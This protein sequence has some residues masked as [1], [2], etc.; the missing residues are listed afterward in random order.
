MSPVITMLEPFR[1]DVAAAAARFRSEGW[2]HAAGGVDPTF[3]ATIVAQTERLVDEHTNELERWRFPDKK[4]QFLWELPEGLTIDRLCAAV[5]AVAG[6]DPDTTVLAERHLKVYRDVAE[7]MPPAHKDRSASTLTVGIGISIPPESRLV[8][9]PHDHLERNP[10]PTSAEWRQSRRPDELP[11]RALADLTPIEVD[12][13]AGDVVMF[14]G[15]EIYHER[16]RPANASVLYLKFNDLGLDPLA[17]D[18]RTPVLEATSAAMAAQGFDGVRTL[19]L[20]RRV[21]GL[22]TEEFF[23]FG[24]HHTFARI[25]DNDTGVHLDDREVELL[26]RV[27]GERAVP[28]EALDAED[29]A[30]ARAL[31]G[32]GILLAS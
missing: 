5:A 15:A 20:S 1:F 17:E 3:L 10:F 25:L 21:V 6:L 9:W 31:L 2:M 23:P 26:R 32:F 27:A 19:R 4:L 14:R 24:E 28:I 12:M 8:L 13:R 29:R 11:E 22:R 16:Y 7:A 18:P 30:A